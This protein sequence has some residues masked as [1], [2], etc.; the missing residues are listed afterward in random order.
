MDWYPDFGASLLLNNM[1]HIDIA[2]PLDIGPLHGNDVDFALSGIQQ[3]I[4]RK[5]HHPVGPCIKRFNDLHGPTLVRLV[6]A[7]HAHDAN[8]WVLHPAANH[9]ILRRR[10]TA[11]SKPSSTGRFANWR[12]FA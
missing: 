1:D 6:F 2:A 8:G 4:Q 3:K 11:H 7:M 10:P 5:A 12:N 9:K